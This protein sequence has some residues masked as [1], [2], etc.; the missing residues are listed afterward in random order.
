MGKQELYLDLNWDLWP[1]LGQTWEKQ[2]SLGL[3]WGQ[4]WQRAQTKEGGEGACRHIHPHTLLQSSTG[5][6]PLSAHPQPWCMVLSVAVHGFL[7]NGG[8]C[9]QLLHLVWC[10]KQLQLR[11]DLQL[12]LHLA[13]ASWSQ[14]APA[15][16]YRWTWVWA[17]HSEEMVGWALGLVVL[18]IGYRRSPDTGWWPPSSSVQS[19]GLVLY[20]R[21][22][23][24]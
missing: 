1:S 4:D 17:P 10:H 15:L 12:Q 14:W 21:S 8:H 13:V 22:S 24:P 23:Q 5:P 19:S 11:G 16:R 9:S 3:T 20:L 2:P 6:S 18:W 7:P